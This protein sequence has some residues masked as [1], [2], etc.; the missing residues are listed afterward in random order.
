MKI[1]KNKI[2]SL[3]F[4]IF[5]S[6]AARF[7]SFRTANFEARTVIAFATIFCQIEKNCGQ[8]LTHTQSLYLTHANTS[9]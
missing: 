9:K 2:C 6:V 5:E 3:N 1:F 7:H 8:V 4:H